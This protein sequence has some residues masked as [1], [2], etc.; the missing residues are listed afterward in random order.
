MTSCQECKLNMYRSVELLCDNNSALI[1]GNVAFGNAYAIF[2]GQIGGI[3]ETTANQSKVTVGLTTAKTDAKKSLCI[4][5]NEITSRIFAYADA[6][7]N[8]DLKA[9]VNFSFSKLMKQK[10]D[11]LVPICINFANIANANLPALADFGI[12]AAKVTAVETAM[13]TFSTAVPA[14]KTAR[15]VKQSDGSALKD[16]FKSTDAVLKNRMDKLVSAFAET[17]AGFVSSYKNARNI[18]NPSFNK[19]KVNTPTIADDADVHKAA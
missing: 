6:N 7:G 2:K 9:Q 5:A 12:D 13:E 4:I 19:K 8:A 11:V 17:D 16:L 14:N 10:D 1:A 15:S 3:L 18:I